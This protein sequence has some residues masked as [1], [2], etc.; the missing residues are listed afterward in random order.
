MLN[1]TN[2]QTA[3][4]DS[5]TQTGFILPPEFNLN[6][7]DIEKYRD[8]FITDE[9]LRREGRRRVSDLVA[10]E[11]LNP[12][13]NYGFRRRH[14]DLSGIVYIYQPF[15]LP[16]S[17]N[18]P[19]Q[20]RIRRDN[21]ELEE[22]KGEVKEKVKY[23]SA[24]GAFNMFYVAQGVKLDWLKDSSI[25]IVFF[26]GEDKA[27]AAAR[28]AS[29]DYTLELWHFIPI[30]VAGVWNFRTKKRRQSKKGEPIECKGLLSDFD[31]FE[32]RSRKTTILFDANVHTNKLVKSARREFAGELE[33]LGA[34]VYFADLPEKYADGNDGV[35]GFDDYLALIARETG[36]DQD[37][38]KSGLELINSARLANEKK[39]E[40]KSGN[41]NSAFRRK[42]QT[43]SYR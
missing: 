19:R 25:P 32:W 26:E 5:E 38:I 41:S 7:A 20:Y 24:P 23:L 3:Q 4:T 21:P 15:F 16:E 43:V 42:P 27:L 10:N 9:M 11:I 18:N 39:G 30:A 14:T 35:N 33:S 2:A 6:T 31:Y 12:L 36:V 13:N 1:N 17:P 29:E 37:A 34:F 22:K 8:K 28:V 40:R